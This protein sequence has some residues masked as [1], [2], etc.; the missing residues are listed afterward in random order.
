MQLIKIILENFA[1]RPFC[2][3]FAHSKGIYKHKEKKMRKFCT[4]I[5]TLVFLSAALLVNAQET[6]YYRLKNVETGHVANFSAPYHVAPDVTM[7]EAMSKAGTIARAAVDTAKVTDLRVQA[8]DVINVMLPMFKSLLLENINEE[9]FTTLRDTMVVIVKANM[10]GSAGDVL[11]ANMKA[12][13]YEKFQD[14]VNSLDTNL[15]YEYDE[16][17]GGNLLW[18]KSPSFPLNMGTL[19]NYFI[20]KINGYM[21]LYRGTVQ[22]M[23][24]PMLEGK[25]GMAPLVYSLISH[26]RFDDRFYLVEQTSED[27]QMEFGFANSLDYEKSCCTW[28]FE[29]IDNDTNFFGLKGECQDAEG[30]W[31]ASMTVD[32]P[33]KLAAGMEAFYVT[34]EVDAANAAIKQVKVEG[35]IIPALTPVI[36]KLNGESPE[37]NKM[38]VL[39]EEQSF[40]F[41]DNALLAPVDEM[42]F[43]VGFYVGDDGLSYYQLGIEDGKVAL[44]PT[45]H[46]PLHANEAYFALDNATKERIKAGYLILSDEIDGIATAPASQRMDTRYHDLQGRIVEKPTHGIYIVNGKKVVF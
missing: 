21:S 7:S 16:A 13:T 36:I 3:T 28:N 8:V 43:L 1:I 45:K 6:G 11:V 18:M 15:Y 42:G 27:L 12:Y 33:V 34:N 25:E 38:E 2:L 4:T 26:L 32:F 22:E 46:N 17:R 14:W 39:A 30:N 23:I 37:A 31:Y 20:G 44:V 29:A 19:N 9:L 24:T 40:A 5:L 35:D 10:T 41:D